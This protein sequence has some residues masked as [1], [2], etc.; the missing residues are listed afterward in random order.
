MLPRDSTSSHK[1]YILFLI[2]YTSDDTKPT[3]AVWLKRALPEAWR[4]LV[5]PGPGIVFSFGTSA[6]IDM[7]NIMRG[8]ATWLTSNLSNVI[9]MYL[10]RPGFQQSQL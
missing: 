7:F 6:A 10:A 1:T 9:Y 2:V 5:H 8:G 4:K 3:A